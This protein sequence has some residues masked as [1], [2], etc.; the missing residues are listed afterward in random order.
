[1]SY[2][3]SVLLWLPFS[4]YEINCKNTLITRF[5]AKRKRLRS[6]KRRF[7]LILIYV[8]HRRHNEGI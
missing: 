6:D 7:T 3:I 1:M 4:E 5:P 2:L 8:T